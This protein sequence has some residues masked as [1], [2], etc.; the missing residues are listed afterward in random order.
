M[1]WRSPTN[2]IVANRATEPFAQHCESPP[3]G[4]GYRSVA[5]LRL[6]SGVSRRGRGGGLARRRSA[7]RSNPGGRHRPRGCRLP[8]CWRQ[9]GRQARDRRARCPGIRRALRGGGDPWHLGPCLI[10]ARDIDVASRPLGYGRRRRG[11]VGAAQQSPR[12][13]ALCGAGPCPPL[14]DPDRD[15]RGAEPVR[16]GLASLVPLAAGGTNRRQPTLDR[17]GQSSGRSC[18]TNFNGWRPR[19]PR[20]DRDSLRSDGAA[21]LGCRIRRWTS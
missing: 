13:I 20:A 5:T 9:G 6:R 17:Q 10:G 16:H 19:R 12:C 1:S 4:R 14:C 7:Q 18:R 3:I 2:V 11:L 15:Q 8:D 21:L